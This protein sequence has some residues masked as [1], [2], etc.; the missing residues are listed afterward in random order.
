MSDQGP[1]GPPGD[2]FG[3][4]YGSP[5]GGPPA[6]APP[7]PVVNAVKLMA[8]RAALSL[9]GLLLLFGTQSGLREAVRAQ[10]PAIDETQ[11]DAVVATAL[12]VGVFFGIV[13]TVLYLLLA[14]QVRNGRS[15]A[16]I[17]TLVLAGLSV[18]S[19]LLSLLQPTPGLTRL[20]GVVVLALDFGILVLLTRPGVPEWFRRTA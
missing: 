6:A 9:L 3:G 4:P 19:G 15:W 2:P 12:T 13:F 1:Y 14:R 10:Q 7:S 17:V 18:A 11:V 16:R 20:L 8:A 5:Y